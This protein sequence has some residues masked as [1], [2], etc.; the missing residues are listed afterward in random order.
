MRKSDDPLKDLI[1]N[2]I[3]IVRSTHENEQMS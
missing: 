1:N 2:D 3:K